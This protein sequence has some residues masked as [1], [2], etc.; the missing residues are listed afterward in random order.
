MFHRQKE[1]KPVLWTWYYLPCS[2]TQ[3]GEGH[4]LDQ[5]KAKDTKG[6]INHC[7]Q[8]SLLPTSDLHIQ[9]I[10]SFTPSP[11]FQWYPQSKEMFIKSEYEMLKLNI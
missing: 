2:W 1:S 6:L 8:W 3:T 9:V 11:L 7:T 5:G 4:I 10:L